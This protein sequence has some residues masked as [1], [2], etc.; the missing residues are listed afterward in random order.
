MEFKVEGPQQPIDGWGALIYGRFWV[1]AEGR[2]YAHVDGFRI[3]H[4]RGNFPAYEH[5]IQQCFLQRTKQV[6]SC[7]ARI[8]N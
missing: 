4:P 6:S 3:D 8:R 1:I 2:L 5:P 7:T